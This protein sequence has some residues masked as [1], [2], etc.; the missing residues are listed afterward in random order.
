MEWD[1]NL[2][3]EQYLIP[4]GIKLGLGLVVFVLGRWIA[5]GIVSVVKRVMRKADADEILVNFVGSILGA[6]LLLV[7]VVAALDQIG[8]QTTSLVAVLGAAG[9]AIG[10]ALQESLKNFAAGVMLIIFRPFKTGDFV[11]A[12]GVAGVVEEINIFNTKLRTPD[13]K[14][15]IVSNGDVTTASIT[16]YS[17]KDTRRVDMTFGI[18]YDD[19][20]SKARAILER[21]LDEHELVLKDPAPVVR[22]GELADSSVNFVVRPWAKTEDYWTV[23]HDVT[24]TVKTTFDAQGISFPF[25]QMDVH[26]EKVA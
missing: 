23:Y 8:V 13:N 1:I 5:R 14:A 21:I 20:F 3:A 17:A 7:V 15:V 25:P 22:V 10:L 2:I 4:W 9:L 19:D 12:A 6:L 18:A 26:L 16:N 24:E 11:E